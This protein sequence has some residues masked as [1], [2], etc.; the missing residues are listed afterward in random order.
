MSSV[1]YVVLFTCHTHTHTC[2]I[3]SHEC[4]ASLAGCANRLF[5]S[6]KTGGYALRCC[7]G[8]GTPCQKKHPPRERARIG[9]ASLETQGLLRPNN[10]IKGIKYS[11]R[12]YY[13]R[14]TTKTSRNTRVQILETDILPSRTK[15]VHRSSGNE[16]RESIPPLMSRESGTNYYSC[17]RSRD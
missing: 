6:Q 7:A 14:V 3:I 8:F 15:R 13:H 12:T 5:T 1:S 16:G 11:K 9:D 4:S 17:G 10:L 2:G